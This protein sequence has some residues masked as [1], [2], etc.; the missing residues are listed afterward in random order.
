[1]IRPALPPSPRDVVAAL[2]P[3]FLAIA[4]YLGGPPE[5][6]EDLAQDAA[7]RVLSRLVRDGRIADPRRYGFTVVRNLWR[8]RHRRA[9]IVLPETEGGDAPAD[10]P[11]EG[12]RHLAFAEVLAAMRRLSPLHREVL[13][14]VMSGTDGYDEIARQ[15]GIPKGT[16]MSRLNRARKALRAELSLGQ[17]ETAMSLL[18]EE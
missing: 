17:H 15:L 2:S 11:H 13:E 6:A 12:T 8:D 5:Q 4:R 9:E 7:E 3:E 1:M 16:V 14:L 10:G 18:A